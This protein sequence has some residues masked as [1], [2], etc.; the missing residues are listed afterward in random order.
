MP[1]CRKCGAQLDANA[2]FCR[3]CGAPVES[4]VTTTTQAPY[5]TREHRP[6]LLPVAILIAVLVIAFI[7][8]AFAFIP[9]QSVNYSNSYSA[10]AT[11]GVT[12]VKLTFNADVANVNVIPM[13]MTN[14]LVRMDVSATG[15]VGAFGNSNN[16]V[17][18]TFSNQAVGNV[19]NVNS[20]ISTENWPF[21]FNLKVTCNLYVNSMI[22]VDLNTQTTVGS[23]TMNPDVSV[24]FQG[25]TLRSTTGSVDAT[26]TDLVALPRNV[27]ITTTTGSVHFTW[28]N[29]RVSQETSV[30]LATTTGSVNLNVD[31][32]TELPGN[33]FITAKTT[34]G[35][36]NPT[37]TINGNIGAQI[38]SH[39]SVGGI[40]TNVQNFNGDKSP[41]YSSNYPA[42]TNFIINAQTTTGSV[43]VNA[44]YQ[45][46]ATTGSQQEQARD[47]V[48]TYIGHSHNETAQ[49]MQNLNWIGGRVDQGLLVGSDLYTYISG[50]WN[51]TMRYPVVPSPIYSVTADYTAL[52]T[53]IPYRVIWVG[54]WQNGNIVETKYEFAQ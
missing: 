15:S 39:S 33:V 37:L 30:N 23:V 27:S 14:D 44:A 38:T 28:I 45:R 3:V 19:M 41:I 4:P 22:S 1:Y 46:Q 20:R 47:E 5:R 13:A 49:F 12:A 17:N 54:T 42:Q 36:V 31:H 25:L 26:L 40:S 52:G 8:V 9:V 18:V 2:K 6:F 51:V 34:T 10:P 43:N 29:A 50:G 48:M 32:N 11:S 53:S 35:S 24:A 7:A 16:P 21:S